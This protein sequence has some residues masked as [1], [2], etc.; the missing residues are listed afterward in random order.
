MISKS[1]FVGEHIANIN[2][3]YNFIQELGRGSY[4]HVIRV[5]NISTGHIYACK[6]MNKR[7]SLTRPDSKRKLIYSVQ[8]I[9]LIS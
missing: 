1:H 4:G 7:Q 9:I 5:Q 8:W 3:H 2:Q 6:K